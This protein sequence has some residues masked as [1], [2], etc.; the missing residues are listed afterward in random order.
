MLY[1]IGENNKFE[2]CFNS[3]Q[4]AQEDEIRNLQFCLPF[5]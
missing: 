2:Y 4:T 3:L 5:P 1:N